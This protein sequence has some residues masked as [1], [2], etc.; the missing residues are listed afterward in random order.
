M[1]T[2]VVCDLGNELL[3]TQ[4]GA[5]SP[6][7]PITTHHSSLV[8]RKNPDFIINMLLTNI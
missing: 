8:T 2:Y 6:T 3:T 7:H 1:I 5:H 4:E